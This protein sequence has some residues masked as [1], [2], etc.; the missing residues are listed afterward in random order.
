[1]ELGDR[2][3]THKGATGKTE[4]IQ[5]MLAAVAGTVVGKIATATPN[6]RVW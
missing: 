4:S 3:L 2:D 5:E 1:M 6:V